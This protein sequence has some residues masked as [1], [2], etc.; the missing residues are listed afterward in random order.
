MI[1]GVGIGVIAGTF[2]HHWN[3]TVQS[4]PSKAPERSA[5]SGQSPSQD[6]TALFPVVQLT[7]PIVPLTARI[8]AL[9]E[10]IPELSPVV[11]VINAETGAYVDI[12]STLGVPAASTIKVPILV[13]FFQDVD[14]GK[15]RLNEPLTM[16]AELVA[17]GS[18]EM[19]DKPVGTKF[20][21][22]E[23]ALKMIIV[24][25]N[26]ATNLLID[27]MGGA[28]VLNQRFKAW[29]LTT[30]ALR[31][32]LPD[33]SGTNTTSARDLADLMLQINQ[34]KLVSARSRD[35]IFSIMQRTRNNN[36]LPQG[37]GSDALIAHKTGDIGSIVG[38]VGLVDLP[39]GSRYIVAVL[40]KRPYNDASA[41]DLIH[42]I[43]QVTYDYFG[44]PLEL[45]KPTTSS[46]ASP[47]NPANA[48]TTRTNAATPSSTP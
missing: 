16:R 47:A 21:A 44:K 1:L 14:A 9:K 34:G 17:G 20:T 31:N 32:F 10:E 12:D 43:S 30:T 38:D 22:W 29:G 41:V 24:S 3:P 36:L 45:A 5:T 7:Q 37:L 4:K 27:R 6:T 11:M 42:R 48:A 19:Q 15:I 25:D 13:A 8:K 35:R 46:P 28:E 2:L 40:V 33:L 39:N 26:T 23:T 18:G